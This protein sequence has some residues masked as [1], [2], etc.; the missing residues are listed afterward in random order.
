MAGTRQARQGKPFSGGTRQAILKRDNN[1]CAYCGGP[2]TDVDHI[3]PRK[4]KGDNNARNGVA[5]CRRCN[6][7]KGGRLDFDFL[8]RG[9]FVALGG[10]VSERPDDLSEEGGAKAERCERD[11]RD[12]PEPPKYVGRRKGPTIIPGS[13]DSGS[14][15]QGNDKS[16]IPKPSAPRVDSENVDIVEWYGKIPLYPERLNEW[17]LETDLRVPN[18]IPAMRLRRKLSQRALALKLDIPRTRL[19]Y[20]EQGRALPNWEWL[21]KLTALLQCTTGQLYPDPIIPQM[22]GRFQEDETS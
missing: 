2:A 13:A 14:A 9:F 1:I 8:T 12:T 17:E 7:A 16:A 20:W 10:D 22:M 11:V 15:L 21:G 3:Q 4:H 19:S 5:V 18:D 6:S